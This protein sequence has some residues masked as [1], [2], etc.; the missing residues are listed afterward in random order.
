MY[1]FDYQKPKSLAEA[2][3]ALSKG[4]DPKL[5]AGGQSLIAA[6]K[7]RLAAPSDL[8]DLGAIAEL[9]GIKADAMGITVGAMTRHAEVARSR[10]VQARIPALA[11]LAGGIGDR[12]VR[13]MGT[14]GGSLAHN[15]PVADYPAAVLGLGATVNTDRRTIAA[16]D[17]FKGM[18][19]TALQ[20]G[21]IIV[22][23]TFPAPKRAAY[24]KF[25][26]PASR[27]AI[28]GVMAAETGSGVRVV[29]TGAASSV[30][31]VPEMEKALAAHWSP[32]AIAGISVPAGKLNSDMHASAEYRSHLV[33]V[34]ARRAVEAAK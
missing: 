13:N 18:F 4:G 8:I 1:A 29:V 16:D 34:M 22:S 24:I 10:D 9:T 23:V 5:L 20:A 21:E 15:D 33:T 14:L 30:F 6:M 26:N 32:D 31:R 3:A 11:S 2:A 12:M 17:F 7:L 27:Y 28:V 19:E 25:K